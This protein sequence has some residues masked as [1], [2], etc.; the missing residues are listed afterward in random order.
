[1]LK[2]IQP[3]RWPW[4]P[5]FLHH[6][7]GLRGK[8][9]FQ[10]RSNVPPPARPA[11]TC[12]PTYA[13]PT[14]H[15]SLVPRPAHPCLQ[16]LPY[17]HPLEANSVGP[18][19]LSCPWRKRVGCFNGRVRGT[20]EFIWL[21]R[22]S[23]ELW[24]W[25]WPWHEGCVSPASLWALKPCLLT[26]LRQAVSMGGTGYLGRLPRGEGQTHALLSPTPGQGPYPARDSLSTHQGTEPRGA[27]CST[28]SE[29]AKPSDQN[30]PTQLQLRDFLRAKDDVGHTFLREGGGTEVRH[31]STIGQRAEAANGLQE[32]ANK[33]LGSQRCPS[34][35]SWELGVLL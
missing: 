35:D 33:V 3:E 30:K 16:P 25:S 11:Q 9:G 15:G 12:S 29:R 2:V 13:N 21:P 14:A 26:Q 19:Q 20:E 1:M 7:P 6:D 10:G 4:Y 28:G 17:T 22:I 23:G 5:G 8:Q 31:P 18:R 34:P 27:P 24:L 32:D